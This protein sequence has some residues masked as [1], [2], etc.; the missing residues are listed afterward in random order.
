MSDHV[1]GTQNRLFKPKLDLVLI[2]TKCC[3][4][5]QP[6]HKDRTL[7]IDKSC[8]IKKFKFEQECRSWTLSF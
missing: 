8:N 3:A 2:L 4:S 6:N 1:C 7:K 5:V